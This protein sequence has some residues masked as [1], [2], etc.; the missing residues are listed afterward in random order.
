MA[1]DKLIFRSDPKDKDK[2]ESEE[3]IQDKKPKDI[4]KSNYIEGVI[5]TKEVSDGSKS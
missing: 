3:K 4:K 5:G 2:Q 1:N